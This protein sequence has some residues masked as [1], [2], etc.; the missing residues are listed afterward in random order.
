MTRDEALN[1]KS[2]KSHCNCGGYAWQMSGRDPEQPHM[3]WCPQREEYAAWRAALNQG[4]HD[5]VITRKSPA[6]EG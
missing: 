3:Q 6:R 1:L 5:D 4:S 2:F